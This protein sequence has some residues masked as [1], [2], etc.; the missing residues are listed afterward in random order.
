M[1]CLLKWTNKLFKFVQSKHIGF[2]TR[3]TEKFSDVGHI[4]NTFPLSKKN[5]IL[6]LPMACYVEDLLLLI[7]FGI[8]LITVGQHVTKH[9][10]KINKTFKFCLVLDFSPVLPS[11][12]KIRHCP[13]FPHP[14]AYQGS[15]SFCF[16][17]FKF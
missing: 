8:D 16:L 15:K 5:Q 7:K 14:T 11:L 3:F 12:H 2:L 1:C 17:L 9:E 4:F 13:Y 10:R 6:N